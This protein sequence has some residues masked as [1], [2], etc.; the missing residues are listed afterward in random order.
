[1]WRSIHSKSSLSIPE[2]ID[3]RKRYFALCKL[4]PKR[5]GE[6]KA[7]YGEEVMG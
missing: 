2:L 1:M 6:M 4:V 3:S 7:L 5:S